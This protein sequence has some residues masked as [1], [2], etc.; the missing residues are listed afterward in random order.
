MIS[1]TTTVTAIIASICFGVMLVCPDQLSK[2]WLCPGV[3]GL[4]L[5]DHV[6]FG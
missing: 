4:F 1:S 3:Q 5:S 2:R 6:C